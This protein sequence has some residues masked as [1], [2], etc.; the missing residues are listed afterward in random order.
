M[1]DEMLLLDQRFFLTDHNLCYTD[2]M[3]MKTGVEVRVPFLDKELVEFASTIE[4]RCKQ[5]F[6]QS[7][8][9][10]K[11]TMEKFFSKDIIYRPKTGFGLPIRSWIKNDLYEYVNEI[12]SKKNI[13]KYGIFNFSN[14][15]LLIEDNKKGTID[16]SYTIF[17]LMCIQ[18]WL[19]KFYTK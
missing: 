1:L 8:N 16:A 6:F 10:L 7:K 13:D 19:D 12:L 15:R 3:S 18:M 5:S 9:I 2:K 14:V 11:I 17:S 4:N